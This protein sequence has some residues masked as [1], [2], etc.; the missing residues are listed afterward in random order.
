M[1]IKERKTVLFSFRVTLFSLML[2]V[3]LTAVILLCTAALFYAR[4]AA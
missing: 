1:Q 4:Y 2:A 3:L